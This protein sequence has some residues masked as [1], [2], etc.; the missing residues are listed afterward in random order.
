MGLSTN[1]LQVPLPITS[2]ID[3]GRLIQPCSLTKTPLIEIKKDDGDFS[4]TLPSFSI[5]SSATKLFTSLPSDGNNYS[6]YSAKEVT[7]DVPSPQY[8][9]LSPR[10]RLTTDPY[11][12]EMLPPSSS[13][14][15]SVD[16][17]S[18][19]SSV[20]S[21]TQRHDWGRES[22]TPRF[23]HLRTVLEGNNGEVPPMPTRVPKRIDHTSATLVSGVIWKD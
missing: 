15:L 18:S 1:I 11:L 20:G 16:S 17:S 19:S 14:R 9:I 10:G 5:P 7:L 2:S 22:L 21:L 6:T 23:N 4:S 12:S 13:R 8:D 3:Q